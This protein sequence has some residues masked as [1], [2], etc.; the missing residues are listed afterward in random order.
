MSATLTP[1]EV[2]D[3]CD[4]LRAWATVLE[5]VADRV[6]T[7]EARKLIVV[8]ANMRAVELDLRRSAG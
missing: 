3:H 4:A 1:L 7:S 8:A 2:R 6:I 5:A